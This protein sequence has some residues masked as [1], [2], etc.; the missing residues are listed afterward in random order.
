MMEAALAQLNPTVGGV[1]GST[2]KVGTYADV[3]ASQGIE[4]VAFSGLC[5]LGCPPRDRLAAP[6]LMEAQTISEP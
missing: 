2:V 4:R 5:L 3:A 1:A 6:G